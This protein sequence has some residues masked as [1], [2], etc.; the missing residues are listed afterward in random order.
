M[1]NLACRVAKLDFDG[2]FRVNRTLI[3]VSKLIS[4]EVSRSFHLTRGID[5]AHAW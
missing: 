2:T 3:G 1:A 5:M 4:I